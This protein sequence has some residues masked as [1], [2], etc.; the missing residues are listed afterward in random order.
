MNKIKSIQD[1]IQQHQDLIQWKACAH[2]QKMLKDN[3]FNEICRV[4]MNKIHKVL[5]KVN[6]KKP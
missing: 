2:A 6:T 1:K 3:T 5:H 4:S